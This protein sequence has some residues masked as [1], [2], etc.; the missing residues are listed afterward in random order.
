MPSPRDFVPPSNKDEQKNTL[1]PP[2]FKDPARHSLDLIR[3]CPIFPPGAHQ[4]AMIKHR[5][6][7]HKDDQDPNT[8]YHYVENV[9]LAQSFFFRRHIAVGVSAV[10]IYGAAETDRQSNICV[11]VDQEYQGKLNLTVDTR[12]RGTAKPYPDICRKGSLEKE[13]GIEMQRFRFTLG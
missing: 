6:H 2:D 4:E 7:D 1:S 12:I 10:T 8:P 5:H 13:K 3:G 11:G 9:V